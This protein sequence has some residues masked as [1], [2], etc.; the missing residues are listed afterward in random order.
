MEK[1]RVYAKGTAV[2]PL[3]PDKQITLELFADLQDMHDSK[4]V[5]S[6]QNIIIIMNG[7]TLVSDG[8][9]NFY[10]DVPYKGWLD[11]KI[12]NLNSGWAILTALLLPL[13]VFLG[14]QVADISLKFDLSG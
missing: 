8:I 3:S 4:T 1:T 6:A 5:L 14:D 2:H 11:I 13:K 12:S 9:I 10:K 7:K